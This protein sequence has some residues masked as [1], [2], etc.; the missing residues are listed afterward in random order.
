MAIHIRNSFP[1]DPDSPRLE[2]RT[3]PDAE[4]NYSIVA[5]VKPQESTTISPGAFQFEL[6]SNVSTIETAA[7][8][9]AEPETVNPVD[10]TPVTE[11]AT[12]VDGNAA[13]VQPAA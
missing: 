4:G 13:E 12:T 5:S 2:V 11:P 10:P 1:I 7:E 8:P 9:V 6:I 3:M